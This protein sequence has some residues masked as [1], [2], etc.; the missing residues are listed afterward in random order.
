MAN[1]RIH[2]WPVR[3]THWVNAAA[4][5]VMIM[6]GWRIYNAS[7]FFPFE[8]PEAITLGGWLG[9]ALAWHFAAMWVLAANFVVYLSYGLLSGHVRRR[10]LPL[11]P[12]AVLND[13]T[14]A[15]RGRLAHDDRHYNAVQK[16]FYLGIGGL[17]VA[18][19]ASG[20]AI[21]KPVQFAPLTALMGGYEAARRV[22][23]LCMAA[24]VAFIV[25]HIV[26]VAI[27]PRTLF[28]M[29]VGRAPRTREHS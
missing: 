19:I 6:S 24:I 21:W 23:F 22:H 17:I 12:R 28:A 11:R 13:L 7:P 3:A 10:M 29:I 26:M 1:D 20:L 5:I 25:V 9:G 8:F 18:V 14:E 2:P 15:L 27:V 4:M 16:L